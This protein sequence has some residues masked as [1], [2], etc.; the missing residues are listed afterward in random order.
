MFRFVFLAVAAI[1]IV[2]GAGFAQD[3]SR[4]LSSFL[5]LNVAPWLGDDVLINALRQQNEK[6]VAYDQATINQL[7][8]EWRDAAALGNDGPLR[9]VTTGAVADYLR[10]KLTSSGGT[11]TEIILMDAKGLN[12]AA[13]EAPSDYWQ[14][15]EPKFANSFGAGPD[16][17]DFGQAELDAS[18]GKYQAQVSLP[19]ADPASGDLIGAIT[20]G[21]DLGSLD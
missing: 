8:T 5:K 13:T 20:I 1:L 17:I 16:G 7:D 2:P 3:Y 11:I 14:G 19:V 18:S 9:A 15:D 6:T 10:D 4:A 12:A 21:V